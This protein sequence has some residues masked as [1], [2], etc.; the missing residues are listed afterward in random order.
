VVVVVVSAGVST[1]GSSLF[2][3]ETRRFSSPSTRFS[4]ASRT[5]VL[6]PRFLGTASAG[7]GQAR[8]IFKGNG[9]AYRK[10]TDS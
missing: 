3:S 4:S 7:D 1:V 10:Y 9:S 5:S 2:P 8:S 6:G